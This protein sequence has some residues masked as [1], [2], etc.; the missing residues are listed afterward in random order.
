MIYHGTSIYVYSQCG[1]SY[2][3][4][5]ITQKVCVGFMVPE[6]QYICIMMYR[7]LMGFHKQEMVRFDGI[8]MGL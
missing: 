3:S 2:I 1:D 8:Q 7:K 6:N 5:F 4:C